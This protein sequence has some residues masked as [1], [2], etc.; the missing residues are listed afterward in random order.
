MNVNLVSSSGRNIVDICSLG[1]NEVY[2]VYVP[3]NN[4]EKEKF[5]KNIDYPC[6][7]IEAVVNERGNLV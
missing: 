7:R 4:E 6:W 5:A 2:Y 1:P 3:L